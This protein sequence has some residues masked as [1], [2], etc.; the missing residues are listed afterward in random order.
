MIWLVLDRPATI[1]EIEQRPVEERDDDDPEPD[2]D[3]LAETLDQLLTTGWVA[4]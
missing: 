4:Q 1:D 3:D 2:H